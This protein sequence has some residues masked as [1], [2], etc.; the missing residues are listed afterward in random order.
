MAAT[1]EEI[2]QF[3]ETQLNVKDYEKIDKAINGFQVEKR[4]K[5]QKLC[6]AVDF[7]LETLDQAILQKA[8]AILVHHGIFWGKPFPI[9]G[10]YYHLIEKLIKHNI[11]LL[12]LHLPLDMHKKFGNNIGLIE[13][14]GFSHS[15]CFGDY[16]GL[17]L[18]FMGKAQENSGK[19]LG[20]LLKNYRKRFGD[21]LFVVGKEDRVVNKLAVCSGGGL[22]GLEDAKKEGA[23]AFLVG[24]ANHTM[25]HLAKELDIAVISGGH[26]ATETI[27]VKRLGEHMAELFSLDT[28]FL[29]VP[30]GL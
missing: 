2:R 14:L 8:D 22:F 27:G 25:Y 23:D 18:L 11:A 30:T 3:V 4:G 28:V 15:H 12:A 24:D 7:C 29:D 9:T 21:P 13:E 26:Y 16:H 6:L 20:E 5:I 17:K 10:R 19:T 1:L